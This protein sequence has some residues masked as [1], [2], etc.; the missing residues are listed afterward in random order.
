[1]PALTQPKTPC[2]AQL[3]R[4]LGFA[5]K[6]TLLRHLTRI[7]ELA[8]QVDPDGLY[9]EDWIVFRITGYRPDIAS[10]ALVPG[11]ALVGDLSAIAESISEA[12]GITPDDLD[13]PHETIDS[14]ARR[15]GVSRKSIERYRRLGLVARRVDLGGGRR[16]V[17]FGRGG[18]EWFE[19]V[20]AQRLGRAARFDRISARDLALFERWAMGYRARMGWSRSR[21]AARIAERSG[22]SHEGVRKALI[23]IDKGRPEPIFTEPGPVTTRDRM[24]AFHAARRGIEPSALA[25]RTGRSVATIGRAANAARADLLRSYA[26]SAEGFDESVLREALGSAPV[27]DA[28]RPEGITDLSALIA[29]MRVRPAV[30][31]YE[32]RMLGAG[33]FMLTRR[34]GLGVARLGR[35]APS[36][37]ALDLIET[38]LRGASILRAMLVRAQ[39]SLILST[40]ENRIGG[41]ID[42]LPPARASHLILVSVRAAAS[43][44]DRYTPGHGGRLA[45]PVGLAITRLASRI[46]DV[47][48][49]SSTGKAMRRIAPGHTITDWTTL[50]TPW[51]RWLG[52]DPR[53]EGVLG[54]L[55]E[56]DRLV[57][58]ARFGIG[59]HGLAI[60]RDRLCE[61]LGTTP[62][63]AA[64][65]EREAIRNAR[66]AVRGDGDGEGEGQWAGGNRQ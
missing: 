15:W 25:A 53:W 44:I 57:V 43:A 32:E 20:H 27:I 9:P 14:L 35:G 56:R 59:A 33:E 55:S 37:A 6:P 29:S 61:L 17:V 1:M 4:E 2:I 10:P 46:A 40:L 41:Q 38:D 31:V 49:A 16:S 45:A 66:R 34:A 21:A 60:T 65:F 39:L 47:A 51:E 19:S 26:L 52:P 48:Q 50:V 42:T 30:V 63:H 8:P 23:R 58:S 28:R 12:A 54:R 3:A 24:L 11:A 62:V 36:G 64:R 7:E 22:H 5:S 18:V 13:H